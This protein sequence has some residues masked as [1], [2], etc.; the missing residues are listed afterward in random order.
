[1][2][3]NQ[4]AAERRRCPRFML[5]ERRTGFD[6]RVLSRPEP[7][8]R[9]LR[10]LRDSPS[11]LLAVLGGANVMNLLDFYF[12]MSALEAGSAEGNPVL[13]P[14]FEL[15]PLAAAG[16]KVVCIGAV[17]AVIWRFRRYRGVLGVA[18]LMFASFAA[19]LLWHVYGHVV[20]Y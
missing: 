12:T 20:F 11:V 9:A 15:Q 16:F 14:L 17:S 18:V 13:A 3:S 19:V 6:R 7:W 2:L 8:A 1:M 5:V 10:T 4:R